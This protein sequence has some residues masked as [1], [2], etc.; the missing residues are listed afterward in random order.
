VFNSYIADS[1][2][3]ATST[4]RYLGKFDDRYTVSDP[5]IIAYVGVSSCIFGPL[6]LLYGWALVTRKRYA[7]LLGVILS[8]SEVTLQV[9]YYITEV[10]RDPGGSDGVN[11]NDTFAAFF[12]VTTGVVRGIF[13]IFVL[14]F[15]CNRAIS[16]S[17][18]HETLSKRLKKTE[19]AAADV[20]T[21][22]AA[23][24]LFDSPSTESLVELVGRASSAGG[25]GLRRRTATNGGS[26]EVSDIV[27]V[28]DWDEETTDAD[29][30]AENEEGGD[31]KQRRQRPS[32]PFP[33]RRELEGG[34]ME[35]R[36][37]AIL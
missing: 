9:V 3:W 15:E 24:I 29:S 16:I 8:A 17:F 19:E 35:M 31:Q 1:D 21:L 36:G 27:D 34:V 5:F 14:C 18:T 4:W 2:S 10:M 33:K 37:E 26:S 23:Q 22:A 12:Y 30:D 28:R 25:G 7:H 32:T 11:N 20:M 13:P 6:A